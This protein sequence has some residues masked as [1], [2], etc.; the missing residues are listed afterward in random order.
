MEFYK[1]KLNYI[2]PIVPLRIVTD[3]D[4][5]KKYEKE[6]FLIVENTHRES[7]LFRYLTLFDA[8]NV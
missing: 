1:N 3:V 5:D 7:I 6:L 8:E 4:N 2:F